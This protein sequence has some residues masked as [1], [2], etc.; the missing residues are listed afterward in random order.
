MRSYREEL[1]FRLPSR[2]EII[3]ITDQVQAAID[4]SGNRRPSGFWNLGTDLLF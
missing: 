2:R 4:K 1:H 3:N